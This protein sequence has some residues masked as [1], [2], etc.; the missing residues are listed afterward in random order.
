MDAVLDTFYAL[1]KQKPVSVVSCH[2]TFNMVCQGEINIMDVMIK[3]VL[4][5]SYDFQTPDHPCIGLDMTETTEADGA[6]YSDQLR[7]S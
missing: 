4:V 1:F 6:L 2:F 7:P 5:W 3:C